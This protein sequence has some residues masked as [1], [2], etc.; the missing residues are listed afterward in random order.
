MKSSEKQTPANFRVGDGTPG[1][2][3]PKGIPNKANGLLKDAII[4]AAT[5]AGG[6]DI[7][8]YLQRQ[9][10]ENPVAFLGLLGKVIPLQVT[11]GDGG[12]IVTEI[13]IRGVE[14]NR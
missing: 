10:E 12:A 5:G 1:P 13:I 6:G 3:R 11:G 8:V 2:G 4:M 7:V 14:P 9:A